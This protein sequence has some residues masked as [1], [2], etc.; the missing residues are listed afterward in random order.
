MAVLWR[1]ESCGTRYEVR[2]HGATRRLLSDGVFHSAWNPRSGLTGRVWDLLLAAAFASPARPARI[3]VLGIGAG[4]VLLQYR[5]FID[6]ALLIGVDLDPVHI[7]LGQR[8]FGL[9]E[10]GA[11]LYQADA[12][13]WVARWRGAPFDLVVDDLYGHRAGEPERGVPLTAAW[14]NSLSCLVAP[15]GVLAVNFM[16][17]AELRGAARLVPSLGAGGYSDRFRLQGPRDDNAVGLFCREPTSCREIRMRMRRTP[18][19]D[20]RRPGCNLSYL[21]RRHNAA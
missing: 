4:T 6:P 16:S 10:A 9:G 7:E 12:R 1:S 19:L 17:A 15:A 20:D 8:F 2:A 3:L 21:L 18:G 14:L 5:R 13:D 11:K